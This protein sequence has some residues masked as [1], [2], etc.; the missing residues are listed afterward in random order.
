MILTVVLGNITVAADNG[1]DEGTSSD[2]VS[3]GTGP[4]EEPA[5]FHN[6]PD[7]FESDFRI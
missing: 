3:E 2:A 1:M 7:Q 6:I 4:E 5:V